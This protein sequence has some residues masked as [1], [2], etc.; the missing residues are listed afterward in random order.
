MDQYYRHVVLAYSEGSAKGVLFG[1]AART[2]F[3]RAAFTLADYYAASGDSRAVERVLERVVSA[4]VPASDEA[5]NRLKAIKEKG[6]L[7]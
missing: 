1:G 5:R 4:E 6:G 2:F 7:R 3:V